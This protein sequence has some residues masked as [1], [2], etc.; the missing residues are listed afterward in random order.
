MKDIF[1]Y[2]G[3]NVLLDSINVKEIDSYNILIKIKE[4]PLGGS[5]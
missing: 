3:T 2:E 1:V 4:F 5:H